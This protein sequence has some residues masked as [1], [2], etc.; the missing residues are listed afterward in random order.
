ML[1]QEYL[2][3]VKAHAIVNYAIFNKRKSRLYAC[4]LCRLLYPMSSGGNIERRVIVAEDLAD[5]LADLARVNS[6]HAMFQA[7]HFLYEKSDSERRTL[8][9]I[10]QMILG[11]FSPSSLIWLADSLPVKYGVADLYRCMIGDVYKSSWVYSKD[12]WRPD[13]GFTLSDDAKA[14]VRKIYQGKAPFDHVSMCVLADALCEAGPV[15]ESLEMHL[16]GYVDC[17]VCCKKFADC[18]VCNNKRYIY[19]ANPHFKGCWA[20]DAIAREAGI[21][22]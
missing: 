12:G 14:I 11:D 5:G 2:S 8:V 6:A 7:G 20:I 9:A 17:S 1:K 4:A 19:R 18:T 16:R 22:R 13:P 3:A 21:M 15:E 10:L